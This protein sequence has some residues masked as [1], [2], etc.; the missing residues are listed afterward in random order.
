MP[1]CSCHPKVWAFSVAQCSETAVVCAG[2]MSSAIPPTPH[3]QGL[4]ALGPPSTAWPLVPATSPAE[5]EQY[6][7]GQELCSDCILLSDRFAS[8]GQMQ[9]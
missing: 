2:Q 4:S 9:L 5:Q 6:W 8:M 3:T 7:E 1:H